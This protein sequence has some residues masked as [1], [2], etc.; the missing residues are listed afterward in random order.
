[1]NPFKKV[2]DLDYDEVFDEGWEL[3]PEGESLSWEDEED[4]EKLWMSEEDDESD[5]FIVEDGYLS[6]DEGIGSEMDVEDDLSISNEIEISQNFEIQKS[7]PKESKIDS[8]VKKSIKS[9]QLSLFSVIPTSQKTSDVS[10]LSSLEGFRIGKGK[11]SIAK[12]K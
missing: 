8:L 12:K 7:G 11:V 3:D 9:G 2:E 6:E 10:L 5:A 4:D 1:M